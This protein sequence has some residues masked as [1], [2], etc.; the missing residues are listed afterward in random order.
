MDKVAV[1][2][3]RAERGIHVSVTS[4]NSVERFYDFA[5]GDLRPI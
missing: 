1:R 2:S 3:T 4:H 5:H